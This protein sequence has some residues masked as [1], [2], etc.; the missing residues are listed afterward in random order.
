MKNVMMATGAA[1]FALSTA[2]YAD[3]QTLKSQSDFVSLVN[4]KKLTRPL[5]ELQVSPNGSISGKGAVWDVSGD[6]TWKDGFFCRR[7][8]W[9]GDDLGYNCQEVA[10]SGTKIR[11]ISD[12]GRGK[13]AHFS[14]R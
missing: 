4:G 14:L 2:A 6:W 3:F 5:V 1:L 10:V 8:E 9:G 11:F 13:S 12:K 7:L